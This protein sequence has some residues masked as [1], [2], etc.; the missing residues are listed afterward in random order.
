MK[1]KKLLKSYLLHEIETYLL[2]ESSKANYSNN[3][4][5]K[6]RF[7]TP[8]FIKIHVEICLL[9]KFLRSQHLCEIQ[10]DLV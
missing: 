2:M 7:V 8:N 9:M 5:V 4:F 1:K 6:P 10:F 3:P